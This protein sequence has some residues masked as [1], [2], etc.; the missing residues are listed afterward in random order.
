M[1]PSVLARQLQDNLLDYVRATLDLDDPKVDEALIAHLAGEDG[2]FK[3]PYLR[4]G[5][6][7]ATGTGEVPL[8]IKPGFPPYEHQLQAFRQLHSAGAPRNTLVTTGTGSGKTEC[9]LYPI[10]DHC[11]RHRH[12]PG[13]QAILIYPMNALATDQARRIAEIIDGD[14]RLHGLRAGLYVGGSAENK[15]MTPERLIEHKG[16]LRKQPPQ[17]LL[18]NYKMLDFMLLRPDER[19][20][21]QH[22]GPSTLR[23]LVIDELHTFDG[24]QGSDVACLLRRLKQRL[25]IERGTLICAGTSATIG[26]SSDPETFSRLAEFASTVFGEPFEAEAVVRET[27]LSRAEFLEAPG[28]TPLPSVDASNQ[29][30]LRPGADPESW[31]A[32]QLTLWFGTDDLDPVALGRAL[33]RNP[34]LHHVLALAADRPL[35]LPQLDAALPARMPE[36][37]RY[38]PQQRSA[39]LDSFLALLSHARRPVGERLAPLVTVQLQL[40]SRE[41]TRLLR[42]LPRQVDGKPAPPSFAWWTE[43]PNARGPEGLHGVQAACR[44]CGA[45][46]FAVAESES[47]RLQGRLTWE[48][49]SVGRAWVEGS[50]DCRFLWP[51]PLLEPGETTSE[52]RHWLDPD[53]G[54]LH[55]QPPRDEHGVVHALPVVMEQT[56]VGRQRPRFARRCPNCESDDALSIVGARAASL[57]SV[58]VS[59]LYQSPFNTDRKLLAFTDSVQDACHRAG[60]I[61]GRSYRIHLRT[62]MQAVLTANPGLA[63]DSAGQTFVDH[64]VAL[65]GKRWTMAAFLPPDLRDLP[66]LERWIDKAG[67]GNHQRLWRVLQERIGWE[68]TREFGYMAGVGRSLERSAASSL[69]ADPQR[70][71]AAAEGFHVWLREQDLAWDPAQ[72]RHFLRGL[73]QRMRRLG[74]IFHPLL[75]R[76][77]K[78][79]GAPFWLS[80]K[81]LGRHKLDHISPF[82]PRVQKP[83]FVSARG[84]NFPSPFG[85]RAHLG[86]FG[87][88]LTRALELSPASDQ[89]HRVYR[90]ALDKLEHARLV[91]RE[92]HGGI[93]VWG[94]DPAA[95]RLTTSVGALREGHRVHHLPEADA[96]E[97]LDQP[98]WS[99]R[100]LTFRRERVQPG[101]YAQVYNRGQSERVFCGEHTGLLE[102]SSREALESRFLQGATDEQPHAENLLVCTPTLEMGVDIGDLSAT[103]LC[104]VPPTPANYLQ[105]VGRAGRKTGNALVFALAN[106]RPHDLYFQA[107]PERMLD[108]V[109]EPPGVFLGATAMLQRQLTA[110]CMD[111]WARDDAQA[112]SL[113]VKTRLC[114][115]QGAAEF[116]GRFLDYLRLHRQ[117]L[118]DGFVALFAPVLQPGA[119]ALLQAWATSSTHGVEAAL[120]RAFDEVQEQIGEYRKRSQKAR[121]R[122]ESLKQDPTLVADHLVEIRDLERH[123]RVLSQLIGQLQD[124]YPLNLLAEAS[125][126]PNYAF[127]EKG[128]HL[129]SLLGGTETS[130]DG[131][132]KRVYERRAYVRPAARALRELAPFNLFYADGHKVRVR[133]L[134]LGPKAGRVEHWRFCR[135]CPESE[136]GVD[137]TQP[138]SQPT[139]PRCGSDS[140]QDKGQVRALLRMTTVRSVS[141]RVRSTTVDDTEERQREAYEVVQLFQVD[142][143]G[144]A[145]LIPD[146]GFGFEYAEQVTLTELNTGLSALLDAAPKVS[147]GG[148]PVSIEAFPTC[149]DCGTVQDMREQ[150]FRPTHTTFCPQRDKDGKGWLPLSIYRRVRSE[151]LRLLLPVTQVFVE[152][153][154][155]SLQA[156]LRFG[157]RRRFRGQPIHLDVELMNEP[158][159]GDEEA[160]KHFLVLFD[161]VP[162]GTGYL[163]E[164]RDPDQVFRLLDETLQGL[165]ACRCRKEGQDGCYLC[166][167]GRQSQRFLPILSSQLAER[168]LA[169]VLQERHKAEAVPG[170]GAVGVDSVLESE[171]EERF[172]QWLASQPGLSLSEV[173]PGKAWEL[174]AEDT[175][176][177]VDAQVDVTAE[178]GQPSRADF[179]LTGLAGPGQD[180]RVVVECDGL[181]YHVCPGKPTSR[182][183]DDLQ[184]RSALA[185]RPGWRVF[186][187][188]WADLGPKPTPVT[189]SS[190]LHAGAAVW[191]GLLRQV[192]LPQELEGL[193]DTTPLELLTRYLRHPA[194]PWSRAVAVTA[195]AGLIE[196]V[197]TRTSP[198]GMGGNVLRAHLTE[199]PSLSPLPPV[200]LGQP[201]RSDPISRCALEGH[202]ACFIQ[203]PG[204]GALAKFDD[205]LLDVVLRLDDAPESRAAADYGVSWRVVLQSL[206][207]LQFVPR[208]ELISSVMVQNEPDLLTRFG[209]E[210]QSAAA[211]SPV[212]DGLE[213]VLQGCLDQASRELV[214]ALHAAG[215]TLPDAEG[216]EIEALPPELVWSD[217][218][219]ALFRQDA[220]EPGDVVALQQAGW[221]VI[222][223][224]MNTRDVVR[225]V[226][227]HLRGGDA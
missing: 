201:G 53:S 178:A 38:T 202:S 138:P 116:P 140:W 118:V 98:S 92:V 30:L 183:A 144:G 136:S 43:L 107:A 84:R 149:S 164:Y 63:L 127:P 76:Y 83:R 200:E 165:L 77:V 142:G 141:D 132:E 57:S 66:E 125:L 85:N 151:A 181:A 190:V 184:K 72:T 146:L 155:R 104:S 70:F 225:A 109:V 128:V 71:N 59:Q 8:S 158:V 168:V 2:L 50:R 108:G 103:L 121:S 15:V 111:H 80:K 1:T 41:L 167:F 129:H 189:A 221:S 60:F 176:W 34:L 223:L 54:T 20:L 65:H 23:Y 94:L 154:L 17:L 157:L 29:D 208:L 147:L 16:T 119:A 24:A 74:A 105:R 97:A 45:T 7:F 195:C 123:R 40:W 13:V 91:R 203:M 95:L 145:V 220:L 22:N 219:L 37:T 79:H 120:Q 197:R 11:W 26:S 88:W 156:A 68:F 5:L 194:S 64:W 46:G 143:V 192:E 209:L 55:G 96:S 166:L 3:G 227:R 207:L 137:P 102:R 33:R 217:A 226:G 27:R 126:L 177:R 191:T 100:G 224:P 87:D 222:L 131:T 93:D 159:P 18:T 139:C 101:Y 212:F 175:V 130:D 32:D 172:I 82:G 89:L 86:W 198:S 135:I 28:P 180:Q 115:G 69:Q 19:S 163:R 160:R 51:R 213:A 169:E 39:L 170:L 25:G 174:K 188:T 205:G 6:P 214:Q 148:H 36:W 73:I 204:Q 67:R 42:A 47:D 114:F 133:E 187:L 58:V 199:S 210:Q 49:A 150:P 193:Y 31:L 21:W 206:N 81:A 9:F 106:A 113:P 134:E 182:L 124:L 61:E 173:S 196:G 35:P 218:R 90:A 162:G 216:P 179:V 211:P 56:A 185:G 62:A 48:P 10:L 12:E 186:S 152:E 78:E 161:T 14:P 99:F 171:L 117:A 215:L 75:A 112:K 44:D 122:I 153:K 110:W 52:L 4:L